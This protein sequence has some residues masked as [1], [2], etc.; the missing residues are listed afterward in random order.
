MKFTFHTSLIALIFAVGVTDT[1]AAPAVRQLGGGFTG[2]V[3]ENTSANVVP[4]GGDIKKPA[5][6][7]S[8]RAGSIRSTPRPTATSNGSAPVATVSSGTADTNRSA[9]TQQRLSIGPYIGAPR[10]IS[11][12]GGGDTTEITNDIKNIN[13][14]IQNI[15]NIVE[16]METDIS[17]KVDIAQ[18]TQYTG[19]A[20]VVDTEGNVKPIGEFVTPDELYVDL[21]GKVDKDQGIG[22]AGKALLVNAD[23]I[24]TP[25]D[26]LKPG[27]VDLSGKVDVLQGRQYKGKALVV[28]NDGKLKPIGEFMT[29]GEVDISGKVDK[30]QGPEHAGNALIVD[31]YGNVQPTGDFVESDQGVEAAGKALMVNDEGKVV[32]SAVDIGQV[33]VDLNGKVDKDQGVD[34]AGH[35]LSV[36][37]EGK[38]TNENEVYFKPEMDT[39]LSQKLNN[40]ADPEL[41]SGR[42]LVVNADGEIVPTGD[43]VE[44]N[45]GVEYAQRVLTV[46]NAGHVKPDKIVYSV[47]ETDT[48]LSAK[49]NNTADAEEHGGKALIVDPETGEIR[50]GDVNIGE[51]EVDLTGKVDK[52]QG[53]EH[54]NEVLVVGSDGKVTD[55]KIVNAN[56][57]DDAALERAK[58]ATDITDTLDW[59]DA[60][61][62]QAGGDP[63][64]ED[65]A[66]PYKL[67]L[68]T[69]YVMALDEY[70][71]KAWF[72]VVVDE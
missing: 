11:S 8:S 29:P 23:G 35:V 34:A 42:A 62:N 10:Q 18:G 52:L 20:L 27:D 40:T 15:T 65:P 50:P 33:T 16:G 38:V 17:G 21:S 63:T 51:L 32:P 5:G 69:R 57:A 14:E 64:S 44:T 49:L 61:K 7:T 53:D 28:D 71:Q 24:V 59:V 46:D 60:W 43:F 45:Q 41:Y 58:M 55:Q 36:N 19:K 12:G 3:S 67:D 1:F 47:S 2:P 13:N 26:V 72:R 70:G 48:L 37:S 54:V 30:F 66:N 25:G 9:S 22:A 6:I 68:G 39:K 56:V 4:S 31:Q